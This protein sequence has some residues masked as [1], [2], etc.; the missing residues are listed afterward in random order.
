MIYTNISYTHI[1][2]SYIHP[3]LLA[4]PRARTSV[5]RRQASLQWTRSYP[6][7]CRPARDSLSLSLSLHDLPAGARFFLPLPPSFR[8]PPPLIYPFIHQIASDVC[9]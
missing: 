2:I 3:Q 6:M 9:E 4:Y 5:A 1:H 7:I 8:S